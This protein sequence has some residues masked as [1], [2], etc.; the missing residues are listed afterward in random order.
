M[1]STLSL[2]ASLASAPV[3]ASPLDAEHFSVAVPAEINLVGLTFGAHPE[4]LWRPFNPDGA[5]QLRGSVGL[6]VGP[7]M[8]VFPVSIGARQLFFPTRMIRP[9][10]GMG[11][12]LPN[13]LPRGH[14]FVFRVDSYF[15]ASVDVRIREGMRLGFAMSPQFGG[16]YGGFGLGMSARLGLEMELPDLLQV[17]SSSD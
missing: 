10:L 3:E 14:D 6:G 1:I 2:L 15:E 12:Q 11:I 5:F 7:E 4:V 16:I 17:F 13:F 9:G 8:V